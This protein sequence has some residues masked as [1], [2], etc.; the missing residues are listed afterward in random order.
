MINK[1]GWKLKKTTDKASMNWRL[2]GGWGGCRFSAIPW[3]RVQIMVGRSVG[4][5]C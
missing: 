1:N 4:F 5:V 2:Q 3:D